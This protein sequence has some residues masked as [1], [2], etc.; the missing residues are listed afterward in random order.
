MQSIRTR[1]P[2]YRLSKFQDA[3]PPSAEA[4]MLGAFFL[5]MTR[6]SELSAT[7]LPTPAR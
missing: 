4:E 6:T 7:V 5:D 3:L 2:P 1:I